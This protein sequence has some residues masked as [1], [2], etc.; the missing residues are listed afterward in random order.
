MRENIRQ[1]NRDHHRLFYKTDHHWKAETGLWAA[2]I[3]AQYLNAN[4]GFNIDVG[5]FDPER[6]RYDV[7]EGSNLGSL[8]R[9]VTLIRAHADDGVLIYPEF[10]TDLSMLT[11]AGN[12]ERQGTFGVTYKNKPIHKPN[13]YT[14]FYDW[15]YSIGNEVIHNNL[16]HDGKKILFIMDSFFK[17]VTPFLALGVENIAAIDLRGF[18]GSLKTYIKQNKPDMV[19]VMYN[20]SIIKTPDYTVHTSM[21]DFR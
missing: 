2:G 19:I 5:L 18:T 3:I 21:F 7:Y 20:P 4:N 16:L 10:D 6:Y 13:Y 14:S 8:G 11:L 17:T 15:E 1:E 12:I 9:K